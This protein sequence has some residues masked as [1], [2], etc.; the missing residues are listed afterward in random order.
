MKV[1]WQPKKTIADAAASNIHPCVNSKSLRLSKTSASAPDG[2]AST[3]RG[4]LVAA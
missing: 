4:K 3:N 1:P 2:K